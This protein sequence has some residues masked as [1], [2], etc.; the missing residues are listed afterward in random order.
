[1]ALG[2]K[3]IL[4]TRPHMVW[5]LL[6]LRSHL[7]PLSPLL[8][9]EHLSQ[10]SV[11]RTHQMESCL[12]KFAPAVASAWNILPQMCAGPV[13]SSHSDL[14]GHLLAT[15]WLTFSIIVSHLTLIILVC[16]LD[17]LYHILKFSISY[18]TSL[19]RPTQLECKLRETTAHVDSC[20]L[21]SCIRHMAGN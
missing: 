5:L 1:M 19:R 20:C 12:R 13:A 14:Q 8:P 7:L 2:I 17:I 16:F 21:N 9:E 6:I 11:L 3:F 4:I 15:E 18:F 10:L